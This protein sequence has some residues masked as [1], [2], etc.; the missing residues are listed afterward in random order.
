MIDNVILLITGGLNDMPITD[1]M[2]KCHPM[3]NFDGM[4]AVNIATNLE[5]L[6]T[7]VIIDTPIGKYTSYAEFIPLFIVN[8]TVT[9]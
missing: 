1:L 6:Y 8:L 4:A 9:I 5:E 3:G 2:P 7:A